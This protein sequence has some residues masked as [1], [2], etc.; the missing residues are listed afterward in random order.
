MNNVMNITVN[1]GWPVWSAELIVFLAGESIVHLVEVRDISV[2]VGTSIALVEHSFTMSW[3]I[4][5][6]PLQE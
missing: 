5:R 2:V 4:V 6:I 1:A 3:R